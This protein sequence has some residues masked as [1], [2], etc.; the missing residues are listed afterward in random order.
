VVIGGAMH[1]VRARRLPPGT[2]G[3]LLR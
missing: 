2:R 3:P 1:T